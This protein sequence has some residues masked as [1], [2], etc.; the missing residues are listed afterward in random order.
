MCI[1]KPVKLL[2]RSIVVFDGDRS[3]FEGAG[4]RFVTKKRGEREKALCGLHLLW[5]QIRR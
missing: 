5:L 4:E 2:A 1:I 3:R